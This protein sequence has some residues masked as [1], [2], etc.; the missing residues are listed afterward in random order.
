[1]SKTILLPLELGLEEVIFMLLAKSVFGDKKSEAC[2]VTYLLWVIDKLD[3]FD[4]ILWWLLFLIGILFTPL[5]S[6]GLSGS[7]IS[8][9]NYLGKMLLLIY[10]LLSILSNRLCLYCFMILPDLEALSYSTILSKFI[11]FFLWTDSCFYKL[12][13]ENS[14]I[15]FGFKSM[16]N[17]CWGS[18]SLAPTM[19]SLIGTYFLNFVTLTVLLAP[20]IMLEL[21]KTLFSAVVLAVLDSETTCSL[22]VGSFDVLFLLFF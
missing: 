17:F 9:L 8:F 16:F 6:F 5:R 21:L 11:I 14:W 3:S 22:N 15:I 18:L 2:K 4:R 13:L 19:K 10:T 7:P 12:F 1:M 20:L